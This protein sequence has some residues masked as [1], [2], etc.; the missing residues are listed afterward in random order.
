MQPGLTRPCRQV[1]LGYQ[2]LAMALMKGPSSSFILQATIDLQGSHFDGLVFIEGKGMHKM[3]RTA[4]P[5]LTQCIS[6]R[7]IHSFPDTDHQSL[8]PIIRQYWNIFIYGGGWGFGFRP[9]TFLKEM[10]GQSV[11]YWITPIGF[12]HFH[13][14]KTEMSS[15]YSHPPSPYMQT[16][17]AIQ[18][19]SPYSLWI[20]SLEGNSSPWVTKSSARSQCHAP[21]FKVICSLQFEFDLHY[22]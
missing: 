14:E 7:P 9:C 4:S 6:V 11:V 5:M 20:V 2:R 22:W 10:K 18:S 19:K 3:N 17:R 21:P 16:I 13:Y 12:L 8:A 15:W 1:I